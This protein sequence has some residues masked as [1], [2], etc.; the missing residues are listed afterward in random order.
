MSSAALTSVLL[1]ALIIMPAIISAAPSRMPCVLSEGS[2]VDQFSVCD[3][4]TLV[5]SHLTKRSS[6]KVSHLT[7]TTLVNSLVAT[8]SRITLSHL[9][10][11]RVSNSIINEAALSAQTISGTT[12]R[13]T[14]CNSKWFIHHFILFHK[15]FLTSLAHHLIGKHNLWKNKL[16]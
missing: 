8:R 2:T 9:T 15:S 7:N 4:C 1:A 12:C 6:C 3:G 10:G 11:C 5:N 16:I 14:G 13:G